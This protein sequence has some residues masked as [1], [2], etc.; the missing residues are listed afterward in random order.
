MDA[1][2]AVEIAA[3]GSHDIIMLKSPSAWKTMITKSIPKI[4]SSIT[5]DEAVETTKILSAVGCA[6]CMSF[7]KA[8][9][10]LEVLIVRS[11]AV[12]LTSGWAYSKP[13]EESLYN[14]CVLFLDEFPEFKR[15]ALDVLHQSLWDKKIMISM[16]KNCFVFFR[17]FYYVCCRNEP[18]SLWKFKT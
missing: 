17:L 9:V 7:S 4:L 8:A 1:K 18:L 10:H 6:F 15:D 16:A 14:N 2:M 3:A 5:F 13:E 11:S 12:A